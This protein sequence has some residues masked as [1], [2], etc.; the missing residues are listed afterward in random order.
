MTMLNQDARE[1]YGRMEFLAYF[2][3]AGAPTGLVAFFS[4]CIKR[5]DWLTGGM[6]QLP[7]RTCLILS[8]CQINSISLYFC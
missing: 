3:I 1:E 4:P 6:I 8:R 7:D 5:A 2:I